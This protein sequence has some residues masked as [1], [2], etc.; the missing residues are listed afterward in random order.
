[1]SSD[2]AAPEALSTRGLWARREDLATGDGA[3]VLRVSVAVTAMVLS[4]AGC[5]SSTRSTVEKGNGETE[6]VRESATGGFVDRSDLA[7][8]RSWAHG[9][10][11][12]LDVVD[13]ARTL[14]AEPTVKQVAKALIGNDSDDPRIRRV[15]LRI[16]EE[17]LRMADGGR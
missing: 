1:V 5:G 6:V 7:A 15:T 17:E 2:G 8:M 3:N 4:V 9:I 16:C 13:T 14:N 12:G 11:R 10:C